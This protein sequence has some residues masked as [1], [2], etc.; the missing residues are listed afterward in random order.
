[1]IYVVFFIVDVIMT[2]STL[3]YTVHNCTGLHMRSMH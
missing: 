2:V 1:M 3:I